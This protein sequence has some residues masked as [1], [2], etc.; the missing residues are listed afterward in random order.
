MKQCTVDVKV[1]LRFIKDKVAEDSKFKNFDAIAEY[2]LTR[3]QPDD[4][5]VAVLK[6]VAQ[7][8]KGLAD[9]DGSFKIS[10]K[11]DFLINTTI[12]NADLKELYNILKDKYTIKAKGSPSSIDDLVKEIENA[13]IEN[14]YETT[15]FVKKMVETLNNI[16]TRLS[17]AKTF[18]VKNHANLALSKLRD[19][20]DS[21][22]DLSVR[23]K[24]RVLKF[25][26]TQ[27]EKV[28]L[29]SEYVPLGST[30]FG[31]MF[32]VLDEKGNVIDQVFINQVDGKYYSLATSTIVDVTGK[33]LQAIYYDRPAVIGREVTQKGDFRILNN[34]ELISGM[35]LFFGGEKADNI[36]N[37][38]LNLSDPNSKLEIRISKKTQKYNKQRLEKIKEEIPK[39]TVETFES[40]EQQRFMRSSGKP[41][42]AVSSDTSGAN[43]LVSIPG[44]EE[45]GVIYD[46]SNYVAVYPDNTTQPLDFTDKSQ[47]D[48]IKSLFVKSDTNKNLVPL[49]DADVQRIADTQS[50]IND[51]KLAALEYLDKQGVSSEQ[52]KK[53][54]SNGDK[55][56]NVK[57]KPVTNQITETEGELFISRDRDP[58]GRIYI[59]ME[60][61]KDILVVPN[62]TLTVI[63]KRT[64]E[65]IVN[66]E[67]NSEGAVIFE[68][69]QGR[70]FVVAK[71]NNQLVPFYKSSAGT[72]G[73]T[74]GAWYPFFGYTGA[75]L[76]KGGV[77]KASGKMSYSPEIDRV[78]NLLNENLVFP[79]KY[80]DRSTNTVKNTNGDVA[81][82]FNQFF[83]V[84]R[85]W[86]K[87]FGSQTG[88]RTNYEIKGL[89]ENTTSESA[90]VAL[91]TGLNTTELDSSDTPRENSEWLNLI[92][93]NAK[94]STVKGDSEEVVIPKEMYEGLIGLEKGGSRRGTVES[95]TQGELLSDVVEDKAAQK[96]MVTAN[97]IQVDDEGEPVTGD[98]EER[99]IPMLI[100]KSQGAWS[101][102]GGAIDSNERIVDENGEYLTSDQYFKKIHPNA[103]NVK[104]YV[105]NFPA[106][107]KYAIV[108]YDKTSNRYIYIGMNRDFGADPVKN[109][110]SFVNGLSLL[111]KKI[112]AN[113]SEQNTITFEFS[114][115][116]YTFNPYAGWVAD[117]SS[118]YV[119]DKDT[120]NYNIQFRP[121]DDKLYENAGSEERKKQLKS[122]SNLSIN[123]T[124]L[125]EITDLLDSVITSKAFSLYIQEKSNG[126]LK[127]YQDFINEDGSQD[128]MLFNIMFDY[129]KNTELE[130]SINDAYN[131]LSSEIR[132]S[133]PKVIERLQALGYP[134][135]PKA[136]LI[137]ENEKSDF[138][139][140]DYIKIQDKQTQISPVNFDQ[141]RL[142]GDIKPTMLFVKAPALEPIVYS[143]A[144]NPQASA[145]STTKTEQ[146]D[147]RTEDIKTDDDVVDESDFGDAPFSLSDISA[148]FVAYDNQ[149]YKDEED[150]IK[151]NLPSDIKIED[152]AGIISSLKADGRILGYMKDRVIYMNQ[153]LSS[154]GTGYHE[155]F[156]AVFR[157]ILN[158]TDRRYYIARA[159]NEMG[160]VTKEQV[161]EFRTRRSL[162]HLS[163]ASVIQRI[164]EEYLADKFKGYALE[165]KEPKNAW[166][167]AFVRLFKKII[168]F[169]ANKSN[170][171]DDITTLFNRINTGYYKNASVVADFTEG[172]FDL[173]PS[174]PVITGT[175]AEGKLTSSK[176][177][178]NN[179]DQHQ[180]INR[181][182]WETS[183]PPGKNFDEKYKLAVQK[184]LNEY[185]INNLIANNPQADAQKIKNKYED[186]YANIRFALGDSKS[187]YQNTTGNSELNR[188]INENTIKESYEILKSQVRAL[189]KTIDVRGLLFDSNAELE[190]PSDEE[191]KQIKEN[192]DDSF[193]NL[194]PMDGLSRQ[195]RKFFSVLPY[196]YKDADTGVTVTKM[197]DGTKV[198][199]TFLKISSDVP[200]ELI[201][202]NLDDAINSLADD[203]SESY[204]KLSSAFNTL[205]VVFGLDDNYQP[206]KNTNFYNQFLNTFNVTEIPTLIY[207]I[208]T[209]E[210]GNSSYEIYDA[211]I[212]K[213]I[214]QEIEK[215][216]ISYNKKY[217]NKSDKEKK[218]IFD[219]VKAVIDQQLPKIG[220]LQT[221]DKKVLRA[222]ATELKNALDKM[223]LNFSL[224]F[225]EFSLVNIDL[226][227]NED[228]VFKSD[229]RAG[230]LL[231]ANPILSS[232]GSY[233]QEDFFRWVASSALG[234]TTNI[235]EKTDFDL[236]DPE[237]AEERDR[238]AIKRTVEQNKQI[239]GLN[240]I[241][242][243][244]AKY[245]IKHN[246]DANV[247]VFQNAE[248]KNVYRYVKY[249]PLLQMAQVVKTKGLQGLIDEY[250]MYEEW[251]KDNPY[252]NPANKDKEISLYLNN[253]YVAMFGG[254]RQTIQNDEK[255]GST[256]KHT[257]PR[258]KFI[259]D[260]AM[261]SNRDVLRKN[262]TEIIT[263]NRSFSI[264]E[265][266]STNFMIPALY[267]PL[268]NQD[269]FVTDKKGT[270][271]V[272]NTM[273]KQI[274]QEYNRIQK[275]WLERNE[276]KDRYIDYNGKKLDDGT[277]DTTSSSLRAYNFNRLSRFFGANEAKL[278]T[279]IHPEN[280]SIR[281][282][283]RDQLIESAKASI[284][285]KDLLSKTG[286]SSFDINQLKNQLS[287]YLNEEFQSYLNSL[288]DYG[289]ITFDETGEV[290]SDFLPTKVKTGINR[291]NLTDKNYATYNDYLADY[292]MNDFS[293]K[294]FVNQ[295]FDG[296]LAMNVKNST[297]YAM[298][299]KAGIISG[300][301]MRDGFHT[302]AYID[303][304]TVWID[305]NNIDAGQ[306][307]NKEDI[308]EDLLN[309]P[310]S[311]WKQT[312]VMDGM[313]ITTLDHRIDMY[314]KQGRLEDL[315]E[316]TDENEEIFDVTTIL[317]KAR[318]EQ[319]T[320]EEIKY[321]EKSKIVLGSYK[322]ATGG[323]NEFH[324]LSEHIILRPDVSY[325][326]NTKYSYDE[327]IKQ[328]KKLL[329]EVDFIRDYLKRG[330]EY[331][332][333]Q[334]YN[335]APREALKDIYTKLHEFY[336]PLPGRE[337]LHNMLNS[338]E[339]YGIDQLMDINSS[340][341]SSLIPTKLN[342]IGLTDF[343]VSSKPVLNKYKYMQVETSGVSN[344]ITVPTQKRQL[345]DS[346]I[347]LSSKSVPVELKDA[348]RNFRKTLEQSSNLSLDEITKILDAPN[349]EI[350]I[351][352]IL[353]TMRKGLE[354]QGVDANTLKLFEIDEVTG[355]PK[356]NVNLPMFKTMFQNYF[357]AFYSN[358]L[359]SES[360]AG[361]KDFEVTSLGYKL[362]VDENDNIIPQSEVKKNPSKYTGYKQRYPGI[363]T[364]VDEKGNIKYVV[365]V[366]IPKPMFRNQQHEQLFLDRLAEMISTR[367]PTE[368]FRSMLVARIV[369]YVDSSY[370]NI[371]IFGQ[372]VNLLSGGD[373][374]IDS[375]YSQTIAT[376]EGLDGKEH[377]YGEYDTY[378]NLSE[379]NAKFIEYVFSKMDDPNLSAD[380]EDEYNK[381]VD[382]EDAIEEVPLAL[383]SLIDY[384]DLADFGLSKTNLKKRLSELKEIRKSYYANY[385]SLKEE[386]QK[387]FREYVELRT[388]NEELYDAYRKL[389]IEAIREQGYQGDENDPV[390]IEEINTIVK[391]RLV[392]DRLAD[393]TENLPD[394][395]LQGKYSARLRQYQ[396]AA[397]GA[398]QQMTG[399]SGDTKETREAMKRLNKLFKMVSTLNVLAKYKFPTTIESVSNS[400]TPL[401][402][403]VIQNE[404]IKAQIDI[405]S[406]PYVFNNLYKNEKS[407]TSYFGKLITSQEKPIDAVVD[408][409]DMNNPAW[410]VNLLNMN[411]AG[412]DNI[413]VAATANKFAAFASKYGLKLRNPMWEINGK[414]FSEFKAYSTN[415][416]KEVFRV[417]AEIGKSIGMSADAK[418]EP[419]P[420]ILNLDQQTM[421]IS[422]AMIAQG[423]DPTFAFNINLVPV[424][425]D[426]IK[427]KQTSTS[428]TISI[429]EIYKPK[430]F[431]SIA[432]D[433]Y[434]D[435]E[436][437]IL[438][439]KTRESEI[440]AIGKNGKIIF[441]ANGNKVLR[442]VD[443]NFNYN[444]TSK[445]RT[446]LEDYG[447]SA[448]YKGTDEKVADDILE[449]FLLDKYIQQIDFQTDV[450]ALNNILALIKKQK[451]SFEDLDR[452]V[453]NYAY[454][455][456]YM[457]KKPNFSNIDQILDKQA[458]EYKPLLKGVQHLFGTSQRVF[459]E[460]NPVFKVINEEL[461]DSLSTY[462]MS[463]KY[464]SGVSTH[465]VR[466]MI[467][468]RTKARFDQQLR[469]ELAKKNPNIELVKRYQDA[470]IMFTSDFWEG[471]LSE[472]TTSLAQDLDYLYEN[473]ANNPFVEFLKYRTNNGITFV[474]ALSRMKLDSEI[475]DAII[476]GYNLLNKSLDAR[477]RIIADK[478]FMYILV[479]DN[480]SYS[481]N[482]FLKY[483]N[484][485]K[486]LKVS[487]D[488]TMLQEGL[489]KSLTSKKELKKIL[490]GELFKNFL[491][492]DKATLPSVALSVIQKALTNVNNREYTVKTKRFKFGDK[493]KL[494]RIK[495]EQNVK[496]FLNVVVPNL[497]KYDWRDVYGIDKVSNEEQ[498]AATG[499]YINE[500]YFDLFVPNSS[501]VDKGTVALNL[502]DV[503]PLGGEIQDSFLS[504]LKINAEYDIDPTKG[505]EVFVGWKFPM[506][507]INSQGQ[508]LVLETLD[509]VPIGERVA[510]K[511]KEQ[512]DRGD[513]FKNPSKISLA[514]YEAVYRVSNFE[515]T[516]GTTEGISNNGFTTSDARS[517]YNFYET[518]PK[519]S[520]IESTV[521]FDNFLIKMVTDYSASQQQV[522]LL[523]K[524]VKKD[525]YNKG[526]IKFGRE[527]KFS[528]K[529]SKVGDTGFT[530]NFLIELTPAE[531]MSDANSLKA[532][533]YKLI[534]GVKIQLYSKEFK[535]VDVLKL[536]KAQRKQI[537]LDQIKKDADERAARLM[538]TSVEELEQ[539]SKIETKN[540][541]SG[542]SDSSSAKLLEQGLNKIKSFKTK[543]ESD[544]FFWNEFFN[545]KG[546]YVVG[547]TD[548]DYATLQ[549]ALEE[550][551]K[552][553]YENVIKP[554][555]VSEQEKPTVVFAWARKNA[556]GYEVSSAAKTTLGKKFSA[557]NAK[558]K[559]GKSIEEAYQ[560]DVK[561]YRKVVNDM[562]N[563]GERYYKA[564]NGKTYDLM[565]KAVYW[566]VGKGQ[567]PINNLTQEESDKAYTN[568]W[569]QFAIENP[570]M[571]KQLIKEAKNRILTD[572]FA[573]TE[574]NQAKA[575]SEVIN[576][577]IENPSVIGAEK[578]DFTC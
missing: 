522:E 341:K 547:L 368:D 408:K 564:P 473:N 529:Y 23:T 470:A 316:I 283:L 41:V 305:F 551:N 210:N 388:Q 59:N 240:S 317:Q 504:L 398:F 343:S 575:L 24:D 53:V 485:E 541:V 458:I 410:I 40:Y 489:N 1:V 219:E 49:T 166:L 486:L 487:D 525:V 471:K 77:E 236:V 177:Y 339:Y 87:E 334:N 187:S 148:P 327:S 302:V 568:L 102:V 350:N 319:L 226:A 359:F 454:L 43:I 543:E 401:V 72:S 279:F 26:N 474:E 19:K 202:K 383:K 379:K 253:F 182:V 293:S 171:I 52:F 264:L 300:D 229:S 514:G 280:G 391:N 173:L 247:S 139:G 521:D 449:L 314:E 322:T 333:L 505:T 31:Q 121:L 101:F 132:K 234:H 58:Q 332:L 96:Y 409:F 304:V 275:E 355:K 420:S 12:Q 206:T 21:I 185:D 428:N 572:A 526:M 200:S 523:K 461:G 565:D 257:D 73:K 48:L 306:Y 83:K 86:Q 452:L 271:I 107:I 246:V 430:S 460:R 374:D 459:L 553:G 369:D 221:A 142:V 396:E 299:N 320:N 433:V 577:I 22:K 100:T 536:T 57:T 482:S 147:E 152:L 160:P 402:K 272:V 377:V 442:K 363:K 230:Q 14:D 161:Q 457:Y 216:K 440:Y 533:Q 495:N 258:S 357:F 291:E 131:K 499:G 241:L 439:D 186:L 143:S 498:L 249:T 55:I 494:G 432:V 329:V 502:K 510:Q 297:N 517:L 255:E 567:K 129:V 352:P 476:D 259:A 111:S 437:E 353:R 220:D 419:Y 429:D 119:K 117:I 535:A 310:G 501:E 354:S 18:V 172:A 17:P 324:K 424:I 212:Q 180:L 412:D 273:L 519:Y 444:F 158:E 370:Q 303:K 78:T 10:N 311:N 60:P 71:I 125:K 381:I 309:A 496:E 65:E 267:T 151:R 25:I 469:D 479:K 201:L 120:V 68:A 8:Y 118:F 204:E 194:N 346:S 203:Q 227:R 380:V 29:I 376:Y 446:S 555:N 570:E 399:V 164:S 190:E 251:F 174:R 394:F 337:T 545:T 218:A 66:K 274:E 415:Q 7:I 560:L 313:S 563:K 269:G 37:I 455:M 441:D 490:T 155:A 197:I 98:V 113:P 298:R 307:D 558:L 500:G 453:Y 413:G 254:T 145:E 181:L 238:I 244:A 124:T 463:P 199:Y 576:E 447:F 9:R 105:P 93:K 438:K 436:Q 373:L 134:S 384:L 530:D 422:L 188:R 103:T 528:L 106:H 276:I 344:R 270:P 456:G 69:M 42:A 4:I 67:L 534:D 493:S 56:I 3:N 156:H 407:D 312:D 114:K 146:R 562:L 548:E 82:D 378:E 36:K 328:I 89:K 325:I 318:V 278:T 104:S 92:I 144:V 70:L 167:R 208:K 292:F 542:K 157:N 265:G 88:T 97:V 371:I 231:A 296:D 417:I 321:L 85:L 27:Q 33:K 223:G 571:I 16:I 94:K 289:V 288:E 387:V 176:D 573:T 213:D 115:N 294:L 497:S 235:F 15:I 390:V 46:M 62:N 544:A 162:F 465:V 214:Y 559:D 503:T 248:N 32:R 35:K 566:M 546:I 507:V 266:S 191:D 477:T 286:K 34:A 393:Y 133:F 336:K 84:N 198:F 91:I 367:I 39:R 140:R 451:P 414:T 169:F 532:T 554:E 6:A 44:F 290:N 195:F 421:G 382:G 261:F 45:A 356:Y 79:D 75:W 484:P 76:V 192:Y 130:K 315:A 250:P 179:Y 404:N 340:K 492:T 462:R 481:N 165:N 215:L 256:F 50:R 515:G 434:L 263:Y 74:Q 527:G 20:I 448:V 360:S 149:S 435:K 403:A 183:M 330:E 108:Q 90:L 539:K 524:W 237:D 426:L 478:L 127:S 549:N 150:W 301:S 518:A 443:F 531:I 11:I 196:V 538:G 508:L 225:I 552:L 362:V 232:Q 178:F 400:K 233:L 557:L 13:K 511:I 224:N 425:A 366:I 217:F 110:L 209:F 450:L 509:N 184:L 345:I 385:K 112:K 63:D 569:R 47:W 228:K 38:L 109:L 475:T 516:P 375:I 5:K 347:D 361:R 491:M 506:S 406:N 578:D 480:L 386:R 556:D 466:Y 211:T 537:R 411:T 153:Q 349:N 136:Q 308:P 81:I 365:E 512:L 348:V 423:V 427:Q 163:D 372:F 520:F 51:F 222:K 252:Y 207:R 159:L 54:I 395:K 281:A 128:P 574:I 242:K 323:M 464:K 285:F 122:A 282:S 28:D 389:V 95:E 468:N 326:S 170:Q 513:S 418:K 175:N 331:V 2:L 138:T 189:S 61:L 364:E 338:M 472:T 268:Y 141:F 243:K 193:G 126:L 277:I 550:R 137:L 154:Q 561:G 239:E 342:L 540:N 392:S 260:I 205:K 284:P 116:K 64:G 488:L 80:I 467:V 405:L 30:R 135:T 168:D 245:L 483:I 99:K 123:P 358:N 335:K 397:S 416:E 431:R 295:F 287:A 351:T 262:K 445:E